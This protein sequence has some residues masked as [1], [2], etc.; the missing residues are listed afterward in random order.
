MAFEAFT[1]FTQDTT[2]GNSWT[3]AG[4]ITAT[5]REVV[6]VFIGADNEDAATVTDAAEVRVLV[7]RDDTPTNYIDEPIF[8]RSFEPSGIAQEWFAFSLYG[9]KHYKVQ[10]Q[11][12]GATDTYT[13]DGV[14]RGDGV[15]A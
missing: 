13:F 6:N 11:S 12:A 14:Y 4:E 7:A 3:D 1:S 10:W 5:P 15:S 9:Y 8:Q 2:V